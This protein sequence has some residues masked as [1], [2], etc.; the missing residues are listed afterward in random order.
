MLKKTI[1]TLVMIGSLAAP[2]SPASAN[3]RGLGIALGLV[4][5][6]IAG[7]AIASTVQPV[8][9]TQAPVVYG[10]APVV[11][12]VQSPPV[13]YTTQPPPVIV[14][15]PPPPIYGFHYRQW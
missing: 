13:V 6:V 7:A 10:A 14:Y 3:D 2:I 4:G 8:Y 9:A 5:G 12:Y 1:I 11:T 15:A